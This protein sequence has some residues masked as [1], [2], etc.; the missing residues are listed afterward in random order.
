MRLYPALRKLFP[1]ARI[2]GTTHSPFVVASLLGDGDGVVF[3]IRP[4]PKTHR[5]TG[6]VPAWPFRHGNSLTAVIE[7]VFATPADFVDPETR[8][9]LQRHR[10]AVDRLRR[11]EPI[12]EPRFHEP[13]LPARA[14]R[15]G[16]DDGWRCAP[17]RK[18]QAVVERAPPRREAP[19]GA[20]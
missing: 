7:E 17:P 10:D 8:E 9:A 4:D 3:P 1:R 5:V 15:G 20:E 11:G 16:G 19:E 6:P 18:V 12:D 14:H 13:A 2:Y